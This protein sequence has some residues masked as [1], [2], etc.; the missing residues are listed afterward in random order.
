MI[1]LF[2][3]CPAGA[4]SLDLAP[5]GYGLSIGN[6]KRLTGIRLNLIDS[7]VDRITGLILTVWNPK[8]NPQAAYNG[9]ALGLIGT[10]ARAINGLALSGIGINARESITGIAAGGLGVGTRRLDGLALGLGLVDVEERIRGIAIAGIWT[11]ECRQLHG[12]A[13]SPV[14]AFADTV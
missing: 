2:T 9:I 8:K 6:S 14:A 4:Q 12:I 10:K 11:G 7:K 5:G 3:F 13:L 1:L